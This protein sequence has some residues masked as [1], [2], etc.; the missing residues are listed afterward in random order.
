MPRVAVAH[1]TPPTWGPA[2]VPARHAI[3]VTPALAGCAASHKLVKVPGRCA[4]RAWEQHCASSAF[5][6]L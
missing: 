3:S 6:I 1:E 2:S 5:V 4:A